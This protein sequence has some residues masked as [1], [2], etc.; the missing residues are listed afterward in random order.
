M[1]GGRFQVGAIKK[2][3]ISQDEPITAAYW[4][5]RGDHIK[6]CFV[7]KIRCFVLKIS[8]SGKKVVLFKL[9]AY[10]EWNK[11]LEY[12]LNEERLGE[13]DDSNINDFI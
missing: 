1:T 11:Y 9:V 6:I 13:I 2:Y 8:P 7:L 4:M 5:G 12:K 10:S 3:T